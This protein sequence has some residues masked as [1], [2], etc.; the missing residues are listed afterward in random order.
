[1]IP[2][3]DNSGRARFAQVMLW[4]SAGIGFANLVLMVFYYFEERRIFRRIATKR[5]DDEVLTLAYVVTVIVLIMTALAFCF[6]VYR[7]HQN[8][9]QSGLRGVQFTSGWAVGWFFVPF[10]NWYYPLPVMSEIFRGSAAINGKVD[11]WNWTRFPNSPITAWYVFWLLRGITGIIIGLVQMSRDAEIILFFTVIAFLSE[12]GAAVMGAIMVQRIQKMQEQPILEW[13]DWGNAPYPQQY[14]GQMGY[15]QGH[16]APPVNQQ[17]QN[18]DWPGKSQ[19]YP[20]PAGWGNQAPAGYG[21]GY[22]PHAPAPGYGLPPQGYGAP[23]PNQGMPAQPYQ[24]PQN[25]D[26]PGPPDN[27]PGNPPPPTT[28]D[29]D[30]SRWEP[31][32]S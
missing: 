11:Q 18:A 27:L 9:R 10:A 25:T 17:V 14:P 15:G 21:Y 3:L 29:T 8:V 5:F 26:M 30:H 12:I 23:A 1:M 20:P 16:Y 24:P 7:A 6:W 28:D 19:G 31:N 13:Q 4:I 2:Q 22:P 32:D